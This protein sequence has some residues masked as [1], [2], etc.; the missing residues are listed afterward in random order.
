MIRTLCLLALLSISGAS[1]NAQRLRTTDR[2]EAVTTIAFGSCARQDRPQ[3]IWEAIIATDPQLFLFI[4][5]NV[6]A[7]YP[8]VPKTAMDIK[9]AYDMLAQQP[10]W[11]KIQQ[12]CH[13]MATWD[14]HD[15][16]LND[17]GKEWEL[18][19]ESRELFLQ[20]FGVRRNDPR[21]LREGIYHSEMFGEPGQ[22]VQVIMLDTRYFRDSLV[23]HNDWR[24]K[25]LNGP[26]S[27]NLYGNGDLLGE[28]QWK[29]LEEE[30]RKPADIRIIGSSIQLVAREHGWEM[31]GNFPH[32]RDRF[33]DLIE[34][35]GANGI[36]VI[37]GDRHL[38][39]ISRDDSRAAPYPIYDFTSSGF[40]FPS[41]P[42]SEPNAFRISPVLREP[43]F[44]L[45]LIDWKGEDTTITL[46][47]RALKGQLLMRETIKLSELRVGR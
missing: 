9:K 47:G 18:K 29:W 16:G 26:Y 27:P 35:T 42:V 28:A 22:R 32:E 40:N 43:N 39:E 12:Q 6:Y 8:E 34:E 44:G 11:K 7:D 46:E 13:I 21:Q 2:P 14:D 37:S 1:A 33:Y 5:D 38:I 10:G 30:L 36:V 4:G 20:F 17:A 25:G 19:E 15:Y 31:W 45:I 41:S 3:D 23:R 24:E